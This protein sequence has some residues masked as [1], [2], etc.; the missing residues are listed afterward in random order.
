LDPIGRSKYL[1]RSGQKI[2]L[3]RYQSRL[4]I[5]GFILAGLMMMVSSCAKKYRAINPTRIDFY[6]RSYPTYQL[7]FDYK[8]DMLKLNGNRK[9]SKKE[10]RKNFRLVAI[11]ITNNNDFSLNVRNDIQ[12]MAYGQPMQLMPTQLLYNK[13]K[14]R[15]LFYALYAFI[16]IP[17]ETYPTASTPRTILIPVGLPFAIWNVGV[18]IKANQNLSMELELFNIQNR[19]LLP[20]ES[21][22]GLIGIQDKEAPALSIGLK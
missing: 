14:Q 10:S 9:L 16:L 6:E 1:M 12:F 4:L 22:I 19:I 7:D 20:G 15:S 21:I 18:S 17:L 5:S 13:L 11:K 2:R 8:Y 3:L